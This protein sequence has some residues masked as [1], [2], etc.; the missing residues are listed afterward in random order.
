[1]TGCVDKYGERAYKPG[2]VQA[3][4]YLGRQLPAASCDPP[5]GSAGSF[6]PLLFG[7]APGGVCLANQSPGCRWSLT[8]PFHPYRWHGGMFLWH[9]PWGRPRWALPSTLPGGART[10][11]RHSLSTQCPRP[12][13]PLASATIHIS[14]PLYLDRYCWSNPVTETSP[15]APSWHHPEPGN[16]LAR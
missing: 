6:M 13:G 12:R 9:F 7:L 14:T 11:L 1:M 16:R 15:W 4:I 3:A 8:P 5:E 10:F 2:S